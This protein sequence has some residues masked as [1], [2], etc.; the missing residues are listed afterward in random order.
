MKKVI[1]GNILEMYLGETDP[2]LV[3]QVLIEDEDSYHFSELPHF[4]VSKVYKNIFTKIMKGDFAL[5]YLDLADKEKIKY[6]KTDGNT[7]AEKIRSVMPIVNQMFGIDMQ[8]SEKQ[9]VVYDG[10]SIYLLGDNTQ[11]AEIKDISTSLWNGRLT[12]KA[13][14]THKYPL[15]ASSHRGRIVSSGMYGLQRSSPKLEDIVAREQSIPYAASA[16]HKRSSWQRQEK[17]FLNAVDRY[18]KKL[19]AAH[20]LD[21]E[22]MIRI[23]DK[24]IHDIKDLHIMDDIF[25]KE[26]DREYGRVYDNVAR[27]TSKFYK[28][29]DLSIKKTSE[30]DDDCFSVS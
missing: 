22:K 29:S 9:D 3:L 30:M 18:V 17:P 26:Q 8:Y 15:S 7:I 14:T 11:F 16:R 6:A 19:T 27:L 4:G 10:K 23:K 21:S 1:N 20:R 2:L 24:A 13:N 5:K 28:I 25:V 12:R